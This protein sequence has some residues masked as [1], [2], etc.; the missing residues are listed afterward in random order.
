[1]A[2]ILV[3]LAFNTFFLPNKNLF[4]SPHTWALVRAFTSAFEMGFWRWM[5][6]LDTKMT[7]KKTQMLRSLVVEFT[8]PFEKYDFVKMGSSSPKVRDENKEDLSCHHPVPYS[9]RS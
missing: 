9:L 6:F 4:P 8:N 1:M 5:F 7:T 3:S 2:I